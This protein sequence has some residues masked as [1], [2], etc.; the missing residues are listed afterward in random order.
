MEESK[1][2]PAQEEEVEKVCEEASSEIGDTNL[3]EHGC[4]G[5]EVYMA[6]TRLII[7]LQVR[8]EKLTNDEYKD[9][10]R[11]ALKVGNLQLYSQITQKMLGSRQKVKRGV[12]LS[13]L[14]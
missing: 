7:K 12:F 4:V 6:I 14:S 2:T 1:L 5:F 9:E 11:A 8:F 13:V 10:R 3:D